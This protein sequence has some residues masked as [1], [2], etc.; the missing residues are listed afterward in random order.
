[1]K[2]QLKKCEVYGQPIFT[3]FFETIKNNEL[4]VQNAI[5]RNSEHGRTVSLLIIIEI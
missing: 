4:N 1:M 5:G 3:K 2:Y